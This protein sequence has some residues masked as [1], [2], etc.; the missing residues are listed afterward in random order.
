MNAPQSSR[1]TPGQLHRR[2]SPLAT[3]S[4]PPEQ[5]MRPCP[6]LTHVGHFRAYRDS[7][8]GR[9]AVVAQISATIHPSPV[10]PSSS[11]SRQIAERWWWSRP[12]AISHGSRY[13]ATTSPATVMALTNVINEDMSR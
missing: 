9:T 10:Q 7:A 1:Q 13:S 2:R 8:R 5:G 4:A 3:V 12:A 6:D 11:V